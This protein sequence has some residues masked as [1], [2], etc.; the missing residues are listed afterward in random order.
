MKRRMLF[1]IVL[2]ALVLAGAG[3]GEVNE[4]GVRYISPG[5]PPVV[6][7]EPDA[8]AEKVGAAI[9][10]YRVRYKKKK[11]QD[12]AATWYQLSTPGVP[13]G[14]IEAA[15]LV[16]TLPTRPTPKAVPLD[17]RDAGMLHGT[18][19]LTS[20]GRGLD[21]RAV[22]FAKRFQSAAPEEQKTAIARATVQFRSLFWRISRIMADVPHDGEAKDVNG[23]ASPS[24]LMNE[25]KT[26]DGRLRAGDAFKK[27]LK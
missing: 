21:P 17:P 12:G 9:P 13:T 25:K 2:G 10:G 26:A 18:A 4:Q 20:A 7:K 5:Q 1:P 27:E 11:V 19:A 23:K 15:S 22:Q 3:G 8:S 16:E 14:W 6:R 24:G